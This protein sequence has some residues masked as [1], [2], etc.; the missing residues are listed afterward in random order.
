MPELSKKSHNV[1]YN[2]YDWKTIQ[3][4]IYIQINSEQQDS[5]CR[6]FSKQYIKYLQLVRVIF[7]HCI[8]CANKFRTLLYQYHIYIQCQISSRLLQ[9]Q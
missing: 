1:E 6:S 8:N 7:Q 9:K 2:E 4:R 5:F 3:N